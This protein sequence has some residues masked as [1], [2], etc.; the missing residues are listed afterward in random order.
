MLLNAMDCFIEAA[1][2]YA[3]DKAFVLE[4]KCLDHAELIRLQFDIPDVRLVN[5]KPGE[6]E[7]FIMSC[8][9]FEYVLTVANAY[10]LNSLSDWIEFVVQ[11]FAAVWPV[12]NIALISRTIY[13]HCVKSGDIAFYDDFNAAVLVDSA[14]LFSKTTKKVRSPLFLIL[15][16]T[17]YPGF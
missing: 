1:T 16:A 15:L 10:A 6:A 2:N 17:V 4:R 13:T 3:K 8:P 12:Y 11:T 9:E 5:L 14:E 7:Q